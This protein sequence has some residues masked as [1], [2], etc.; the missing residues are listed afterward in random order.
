MKRHAGA[1]RRC[2]PLLLLWPLAGALAQNLP[3]SAPGPSARTGA[4]VFKKYCVLCHGDKADGKGAA[5]HLHDPRPADLRRSAYPDSYKETIIR[6]GGKALGRSAGMPPW[7]KELS[8][9]QIKNVV[10]YLRTLKDARSPS[11][12]N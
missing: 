12:G 10:A 3:A 11:H 8:D 6:D 9:A 1:G 5:A 2:L 4:A 7:G